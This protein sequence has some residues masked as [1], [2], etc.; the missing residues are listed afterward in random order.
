MKS[1]NNTNKSKFILWIIFIVL[2]VT[3]ITLTLNKVI[4][5]NKD[6]KKEVV[7]NKSKNKEVVEGSKSS[8]NDKDK[9]LEKIKGLIENDNKGITEI[10]NKDR[11]SEYEIE[12]N[13]LVIPDVNLV[14]K[15]S[16]EKNLLRKEAAKALE[17]MLKDAKEEGNLEIF[18]CSA[19]RSEDRQLEV[20]NAKIYKSGEKGNEY[21]AEP[22]H[23]EHQTG[24]AADLTSKT[25]KFRLE[26]RFEKCDEGKWLMENAHKY[27]F[28]LRYP[29]DKEDETGYNYEPWHYRYIGVE[30]STYLKENDMT[31]EKL[32]EKIES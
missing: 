26:E 13:E 22:G 28:T 8:K 7:M 29:K 6:E 12:K 27:G 10:I 15:R 20:Y 5:A 19:Y 21:V 1:S 3:L 23:S 25:M 24:L 32:Y 4:L 14:A 11:A 31:L 30:I 9:E 18:L 2:I 17:K 16:D